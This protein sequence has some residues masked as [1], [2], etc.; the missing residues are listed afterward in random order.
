MRPDGSDLEYHINY[1][2]SFLR[3]V[4]VFKGK[5]K[6]LT[7][8]PPEYLGSTPLDDSKKR[9]KDYL[10]LGRFHCERYSLYQFW[11]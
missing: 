3:A 5:S 4:K 2:Y 9:R 8:I 10:H 11:I 1:N 7:M 6:N